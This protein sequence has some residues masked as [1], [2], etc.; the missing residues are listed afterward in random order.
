MRGLLRFTFLAGATA[1]RATAAGL[2]W[3]ANHL[4]AASWSLERW[5]WP[6]EGRKSR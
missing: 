5:T 1:C 6:E 3:A 2:V 4:L